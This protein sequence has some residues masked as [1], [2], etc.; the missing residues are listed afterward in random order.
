MVTQRK[1]LTFIAKRIAAGGTIT[2]KDVADE[3]WISTDSACGHLR[4]LWR[5]RLIEELLPRPRGFRHRPEQ[6]EPML[7]LRFFVTR[8]GKARLRWY[9]RHDDDGF[10]L[11]DVF[12]LVK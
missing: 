3:F 6:G 7:A 5:E 11:N 10:S 8:R 1:V 4:R 12:P 2:A 9:E